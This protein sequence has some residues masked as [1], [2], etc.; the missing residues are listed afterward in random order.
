VLR[1]NARAAHRE[2]PTTKPA[3]PPERAQRNVRTICSPA[4]VVV[5]SWIVS[6]PSMTRISRVTTLPTSPG[7][8]ELSS[9]WALQAPKND[10]IPRSDVHLPA[11]PRPLGY[12]DGVADMRD[13]GSAPTER[14]TAAEVEA[15]SSPV[16]RR[17]AMI[18]RF[19]VLGPLGA[20]GTG[21]VLSAYDPD[22][23]RKVAIKLLHGSQWHGSPA[24]T[25]E[26]L[27]QEAQTMARLAHPNVVAV[28]EFGAG[29]GAPYVV[30]ELV[31]GS[32]LRGWLGAARPWPQVV[33]LFRQA[34]AGLAAA[35]RAGIVHRDF[36]PENVLVGSDGRARVSDFGLAF[37]S[38]DV[39]ARSPGTFAGTPPYMSPEQRR[40]GSTD[41][42]S[43]QFSFCVALWEALHGERPFA[44]DRPEAP[45]AQPKR[46]EV[47]GRINAVVA[48]GLAVDPA[49]RWPS[50]EAL[51][52]ALARDPSAA[53]RRAGAA[54]AIVALA[55]A[56]V[57]MAVRPRTAAADPCAGA[58]ARLAG[59]WDASRKEQ[60]RLAFAATR[61][62]YADDAWRRVGAAVDD[63]TRRW[64]DMHDEACRATRV[65]GRQSDTLMDLRMACLERRRAALGAVTDLWAT[66]MDADA[67]AGAADAAGRLA[68]L[69]EC[70]D[71]RALLER[72]PLPADPAAL[73]KIAVARARLDG[74]YA[75]S[76]ARRWQPAR[77]AAAAA[78]ADADAS[79]WPEVR[80]EAAF[81]E[82]E[83][84][85]RLEDPKAEA[86]L[87][88][89]VHQAGAARDDGL[90]ARALLTLANDLATEHQN[91][92]RA[93]LVSAIA[94]GAVARAGGDDALVGRLLQTR[95]EALYTQG[96]YAAA[97]EAFVGA[98]AR[99]AAAFG[100]GGSDVAT[101]LAQLADTA[102]AQGDYTTAHKLGE[103]ALAAMIAR[104]GPE[105][106][107]VAAV[108]NNLGRTA[109]AGGD[110]EAALA[111]YRRS[112][113]IKEKTVGPDSAP[114]AV[115]LNNIA[116]VNNVMGH[117][118]EAAALFLRALAIWE[119]VLGP[120]H[121]NV[122][123]VLSNLS[124]VR[125]KQGRYDEAIDLG[126]RA[127][128]LLERA[129]GPSHAAVANTLATLGQVLLA[130][131]DF[132]GALSY[133]QRALEVRKKVLGDSHPRT[134]HSMN[135]VADALAGLHRYGE[136]RS[137]LE[138]SLAGLEKA[139]GPD[140]P[141]VSESLS[142]LARCDVAQ[143]RAAAA[144]PLLERAIAIDE[145]AGEDVVDRGSMH[146]LMAQAQWAVGRRDAAVAA[147][148][149][150][151]AELAQGPPTGRDLVAARTWLARQAR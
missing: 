90:A 28:Y 17:G 92:E 2:V 15:G 146:W 89:A 67:L 25:Q 81:A 77:T 82:G 35:H 115:T 72:T 54:V 103:E 3:Y 85:T 96:R 74:V 41:A 140:H 60:L 44:D 145:K 106:P 84:L 147:A 151:E 134:F 19:V 118:D 59:V 75:L 7:D 26:R 99:Y 95:G 18:G 66:G 4:A 101:T 9:L 104:L 143:G 37:A 51:L 111:Y 148:R 69:A 38:A 71:A 20:G 124:A 94:E 135:L 68:P 105:H 53:R 61:L 14:D 137:L 108:L 86:P 5:R 144:I 121:P 114:V 150:A 91:A 49:E 48:R 36:K 40:G 139:A 27:T 117:Y 30:M 100:D 8:S 122:A 22:L 149:K 39:D 127:L 12:H 133:F 10:R 141:D 128:A 119:R 120:E 78:R 112:L 131:G 58:G 50:M 132:T 88:E 34:G 73:A 32:T 43:D 21:V 56:A 13:V 57:W 129:Y 97:A 136:A 126:Q 130:K 31:D 125:S 70:A 16:A 23:D 46:S 42:R 45:R 62:A 110:H 65:E 64:V 63:Y 76:A 55:V 24:V 83:I 11:R 123:G 33:E 6:S 113:A 52:A 80:A 98:R 93:L 142:L 109:N 47:P 87:L 102:S 107:H 29:E 1:A 138:V 116:S 79:G